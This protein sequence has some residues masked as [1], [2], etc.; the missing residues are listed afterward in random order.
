MKCL[1]VMLA[2]LVVTLRLVSPRGTNEDENVLIAQPDASRETSMK[3]SLFVLG[4]LVG[5]AW[6]A[7][8]AEA[9]DYPWCAYYRNGSTN[10]GFSTFQ[11]CL[12]TVRGIGGDCMRNTQYPTAGDNSRRTRRRYDN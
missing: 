3:L 10:C 9:T 8:P 11:Q 6:I 5:A 1:L 4:I 2:I 12:D 7:T